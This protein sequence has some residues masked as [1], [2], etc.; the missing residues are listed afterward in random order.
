M[1]GIMPEPVVDD[2]GRTSLA[3]V[4]SRDYD[5]YIVEESPNGGSCT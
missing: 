1:E 2:C 3:W 4:R 5:R